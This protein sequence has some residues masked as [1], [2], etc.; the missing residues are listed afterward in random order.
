MMEGEE[1]RKRETW[2]HLGGA[3]PEKSFA[4]GNE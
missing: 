2:E 1:A 4:E 3:Y